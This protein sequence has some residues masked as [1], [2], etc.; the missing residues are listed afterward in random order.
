MMLDVK[1]EINFK[2]FLL[3]LEVL[4]G[5]M[6]SGKLYTSQRASNIMRSRRL[7]R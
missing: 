4:K 2:C 3:S 6:V 5:Y 7:I 1:D